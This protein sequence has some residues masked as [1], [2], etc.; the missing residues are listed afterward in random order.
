MK[1]SFLIDRLYNVKRSLNYVLEHR[2]IS[3]INEVLTLANKLDDFVLIVE[4]C[5]VDNIAYKDAIKNFVDTLLELNHSLLTEES[6][7]IN[8]VVEQANILNDFVDNMSSILEDDLCESLKIEKGLVSTERA[9]ASTPEPNPS[10]TIFDFFNVGE[11]SSSAS[12]SS[13]SSTIYHEEINLPAPVL[14]SMPFVGDH[15]KSI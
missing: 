1:N 5:S 2:G 14:T 4:L 11:S 12:A 10:A 13:N 3:N 15:P 7:G 9:G 6:I 8:G